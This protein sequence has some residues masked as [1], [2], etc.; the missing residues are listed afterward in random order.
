M[1]YMSI[2]C[3]VN[4][5]PTTRCIGRLAKEFAV[6]PA[7]VNSKSNA[8]RVFDAC[9]ADVIRRELVRVDDSR[10]LIGSAG[11]PIWVSGGLPPPGSIE[12]IAAGAVPVPPSMPS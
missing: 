6:S 12:H 8:F 2:L 10:Q 4:F 1:L 9:F 7:V 3:S 5:D 11:K